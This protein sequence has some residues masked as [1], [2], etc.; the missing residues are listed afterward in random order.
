MEETEDT[1][2]EKKYESIIEE[3]EEDILLGKRKKGI[4]QN[5]VLVGGKPVIK[6]KGSRDGEKDDDFG[7]KPKRF[8]IKQNS[9][10]NRKKLK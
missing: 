6:I 8:P 5:E 7:N 1:V 4:T 2:E 10:G 3:E 9:P